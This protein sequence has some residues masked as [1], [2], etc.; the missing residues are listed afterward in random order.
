VNIYFDNHVYQL[1]GD[2]HFNALRYVNFFYRWTNLNTGDK[3]EQFL[4]L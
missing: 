3:N 4:G 1:K 2:K